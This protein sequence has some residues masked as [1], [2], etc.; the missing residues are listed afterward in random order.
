MVNQIDIY[1]VSTYVR[2]I[3]SAIRRVG[4]GR[5]KRQMPIITRYKHI[6]THVCGVKHEEGCETIS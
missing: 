6:H 5:K 1:A 2:K 3:N 4:S